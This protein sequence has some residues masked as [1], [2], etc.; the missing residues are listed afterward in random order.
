MQ[1]SR[2]L[3]FMAGLAASGVSTS[4]TLLQSPQLPLPFSAPLYAAT[5]SSTSGAARKGPMPP[6]RPAALPHSLTSEARSRRLSLLTAKEM[7]RRS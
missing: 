6:P 1:P 3:T 2:P 7:M 5:S 4:S